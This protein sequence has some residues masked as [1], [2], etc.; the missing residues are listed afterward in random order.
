M[1]TLRPVLLALFAN[2]QDAYLENLIREEKGISNIFS[3]LDDKGVIKFHKEY[4]ASTDELIKLF[5][6]YHERIILLHFAGH[7]GG[8][9]LQFRGGNTH[10]EGLAQL[11][12]NVPVVFLNGCAT[13]GHVED[14][15]ENGVKAVIATESAINDTTAYE[16]STV[17]YQMLVNGQSLSEAFDLAKA[18]LD[19]KYAK[20]KTLQKGLKFRRDNASE[21]EWGLYIEDESIYDWILPIQ[22]KAVDFEGQKE[23]RAWEKALNENDEQEYLSFLDAFPDTNRGVDALRKLGELK[24]KEN[25]PLRKNA[26]QFSFVGR[27]SE[28]DVLAESFETV[29][30]DVFSSVLIKG[31]LGI[32]KNRIIDEFISKLVDDYPDILVVETIC[33]SKQ[34]ITNPYSVFKEF[35]T[36]LI[37]DK[38]KTY[39]NQEPIQKLNPAFPIWVNNI[40]EDYSGLLGNIVSD[41][42]VTSILRSYLTRKNKYFAKFE[43]KIEVTEDEISKENLN[44]TLS[45]FF[46]E[47]SSEFPIIFVIKN[48]HWVNRS[49]LEALLQIVDDNEDSPI[50]LICSYRESDWMIR[51]DYDEVVE[52]LDALKENDN[53]YWIDLDK[54]DTAE[55][56]NFIKELIDTEANQFDDDFKNQIF[57]IVNGNTLFVI[58]LLKYLQKNEFIIKNDNDEWIVANEINW[59]LIP[60]K[61]EEVIK[62]RV[63][64]LEESSRKF[65]EIASLQGSEFIVQAVKDIQELGNQIVLDKAKQLEKTYKFI[66]E[67]KVENVNDSVFT[68]FEFSNVLVQQFFYQ[69]LSKH[70]RMLFHKELAGILENLYENNLS[71][72]ASTLA[73]HYKE[74]GDIIKALFYLNLEIKEA[75]KV[76]A[77]HE[78]SLDLKEQLNLIKEL[79]EK[80]PSQYND[81][82]KAQELNALIQISICY[83]SIKGWKHPKVL[84]FYDKAIALGTKLRLDEKISPITFGYWVV[85][86]LELNL[87]K[88]LVLAKD[89]LHQGKELKNRDIILQARISL[90]NTQYYTG[91]LIDA[92]GN[93]DAFFELVNQPTDSKDK[94][95]YGQDPRMLA[96]LLE[97]LTTSLLGTVEKT[98][99]TLKELIKFTDDLNHP[100][101]TAIGIQAVA[102][103]YQVIRDYEEGKK[104]VDKLISISQEYKFPFYLGIGQF[105]KGLMLIKE[106]EIEKG[107]KLLLGG[108]TLM[109]EGGNKILHGLKAVGEGLTYLKKSEYDKGI[110]YLIEEIEWSK[111]HSE[112]VY[113]PEMYQVKGLLELEKKEFEAAKFSFLEGLD[114]AITKG[115][116][117]YELSLLL[118]T[119][120]LPKEIRSD[121]KIT[122]KLKECLNKF[123]PTETFSDF[124]AAKK[125]IED[126]QVVQG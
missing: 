13:Q 3:P 92:K 76:C 2:D 45:S 44:E 116:L 63:L 6:R 17:F 94:I 12:K 4:Y 32:G 22:D 80:T 26:N 100:F 79:E 105:L 117:L 16:F 119:T 113:L 15:L 1:E 88:A 71:S 99:A 40:I 50:L 112:I 5:V 89:Y 109:N 69:N 81:E 114:I 90:A 87:D 122:E 21:F 62:K 102:W 47:L 33:T 43:E 107:S 70:E 85:S 10:Q 123:S 115:I 83:K 24:F 106:S 9:Q 93:I 82:I 36:D 64:L 58:E 110:S 51:E 59:S 77:Y 104:Y 121:L 65:L 66:S 95:D 101:S 39:E 11:L 19:T 18:T 23:E 42:K 46:H 61:L 25:K 41:K 78:A 29:T 31:E 91:D 118:S 126:K 120:M 125:Y 54:K 30:D 75:M 67:T 7:A 68:Y 97:I 27:N 73:H 53:N 8:T 14:L 86:L 37:K 72:Q 38:Y 57:K 28:L 74:G 35:F 55:K 108:Y 49:S 48:F 56:I 124:L 34:D 20:K 111:S 84:E 60:N 103:F 96:F 98:Q 52:L